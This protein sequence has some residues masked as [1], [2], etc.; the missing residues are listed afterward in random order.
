MGYHPRIESKTMASFVTT[1]SRNSELWFI[2]NEPLAEAI[3]GYLAKFATRYGVRLYAYAIEGNHIQCPAIFPNG[4]RADFMRD[5]NSCVARAIPRYCPEYPG[6][7]YWGR[8]YSSEFLP[9]NQDVENEF[10]YTVLQPVNDGLVEK[11]SDYPGYNCFHDAVH[12]IPRKYKVI[13]WG[14]YNADSRY[15]KV[16]IE[17]YTEIAVLQ[18]E[19]LPGYEHLTQKQ[20]AAMMFQKLEDRRQVVVQERYRNGLGFAG[21]EK[22]LKTKPGS[23]PKKT[24]TSSRTDHRPRVLSIDNVRRAECNA[25]YFLNHFEYKDCSRRYRAG[26]FTVEFPEGMYRPYCPARPPNS[27]S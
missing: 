2:N 6:G 9:G 24:K 10:F 22:L 26:D 4:N 13:N 7:R 16:S 27:S 25:W 1:R 5:L 19:R 8:R 17:D 14:K 21:R 15:K 20:Y 3:L 18:Y 12:A 11:I 23:R